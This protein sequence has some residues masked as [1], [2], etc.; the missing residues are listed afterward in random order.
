MVVKDQTGD[1]VEPPLFFATTFQKYVVPFASGPGLADVEAVVPRS[2]GAAVVPKYT[3]YDVA[4]PAVD[5]LS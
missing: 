1:D 4:P 2:P 3:S 5:Q